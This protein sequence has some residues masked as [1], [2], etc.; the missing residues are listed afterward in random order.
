MIRQYPAEPSRP[1][2]PAV[3]SYLMR[4]SYFDRTSDFG[5]ILAFDIQANFMV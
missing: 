3:T 1:P 4:L 5:T 2:T